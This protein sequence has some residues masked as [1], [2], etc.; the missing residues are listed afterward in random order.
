MFQHLIKERKFSYH[1]P[2]L[3][4]L[5]MVDVRKQ[6]SYLESENHWI[7]SFIFFLI[8][9][10]F[11]SFLKNKQ[12]ISFFFSN[13]VRI[14]SHWILSFG[15]FFGILKIHFFLFNFEKERVSI[16]FRLSY[17]LKLDNIFWLA[18]IFWRKFFEPRKKTNIMKFVDR[19]I[20]FRFRFVSFGHFVFISTVFCFESFG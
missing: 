18:S 15:L 14:F 11:F 12:K 16:F 10:I 6:R 3:L 8:F 9:I 5:L 1:C 4:M 13:F 2:L 20:S 19:F 17:S 7:F